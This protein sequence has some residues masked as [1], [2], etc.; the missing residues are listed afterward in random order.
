MF[1]EADLLFQLLFDMFRHI[2]GRLLPSGSKLAGRRTPIITLS[3]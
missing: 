1:Q 3:A 2:S